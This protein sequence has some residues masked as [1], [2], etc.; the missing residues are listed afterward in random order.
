MTIRAES[1]LEGKGSETAE[2]PSSGRAEDACQ[3]IAGLEV[4]MLYFSP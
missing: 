3:A 1:G 4:G 2:C